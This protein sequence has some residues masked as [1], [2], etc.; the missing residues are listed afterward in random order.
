MPTCLQRLAAR[1]QSSLTWDDAREFGRLLH[2][3]LWLPVLNLAGWLRVRTLRC[4][5][6]GNR[7]LAKYVLPDGRAVLLCT[8]G[9]CDGTVYP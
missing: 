5:R 3:R 7:T 6:C 2:W 1:I 8:R 4:P 9:G